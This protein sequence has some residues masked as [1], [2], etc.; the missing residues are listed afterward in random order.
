MIN[1]YI[2]NLPSEVE[3]IK[4]LRETLTKAGNDKTISFPYPLP[5]A[6][7]QILAKHKYSVR[8]QGN[9]T[10]IKDDW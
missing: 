3:I 1:E 8:R 10:I 7:E 6:A 2:E 9:N 4:L 5:K